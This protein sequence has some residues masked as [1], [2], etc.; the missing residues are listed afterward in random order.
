MDLGK[1]LMIHIEKNNK[2]IIFELLKK[3]INKL[4][5]TKFSYK[6][7]VQLEKLKLLAFKGNK[8]KKKL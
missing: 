2:W 3:N 8:T 5:K 7:A 1:H 4:N 6:T